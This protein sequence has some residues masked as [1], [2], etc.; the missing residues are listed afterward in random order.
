MK[1]TDKRIYTERLPSGPSFD[2]LLVEGG[3]FQMGGTDE[4]AIDREKPIHEV[5]VPTFYLGKYPVTQG[6]WEAIMGNNPSGYKGPRHPVENVSWEDV[7]KFLQRLNKET[8]QSYRLPTEAEWEFAARG[9][10]HTEEYLYAGSDKLSEVGWYDDNAGNGTKVVGQLLENELGLF[11]MSGN[12]YEWCEDDYHDNYEGAPLDGS[13][14][15]DR[16]KRGGSR[17]LRGG[18]WGGAA[19]RCRVSDRNHLAPVVRNDFVGFRLV[20]PRV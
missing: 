8:K 15:I 17:V 3:S 11:D 6:L 16:P 2:M 12:V 5:E 13:A 4:E 18:A 9:G 1:T 7:Q 14:W 10:I 19:R 20:L